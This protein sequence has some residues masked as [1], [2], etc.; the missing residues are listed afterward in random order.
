MLERRV[1][2][3]A[4]DAQRMIAPRVRR[5]AFIPK[6]YGTKQLEKIIKKVQKKSKKQ[7][8]FSKTPPYTPV[9]AWI[10]VYLIPSREWKDTKE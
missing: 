4:N 1:A 9:K 10:G 8:T 3:D 7:K 6:V 2:S 5:S